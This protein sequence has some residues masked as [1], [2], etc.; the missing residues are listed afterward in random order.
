M[1]PYHDGVPISDGWIR[2]KAA[3][4]A[5]IDAQTWLLVSI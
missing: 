5:E 2:K 3:I 4:C 1:G